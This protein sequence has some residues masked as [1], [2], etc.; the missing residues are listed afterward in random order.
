MIELSRPVR[1]STAA[2]TIDR[3]L[4]G[5]HVTDVVF[6]V[7][8]QV[9]RCKRRGASMRGL[10]LRLLHPASH[11]RLISSNWSV[12]SAGSRR[13]WRRISSTA[14][15]VSRLAW[16]EKLSAPRPSP[17][18]DHPPRRPGRPGHRLRR[19]PACAEPIQLVAQLL[20]AEFLC[21]A[22]HQRRQEAGRGFDSLSGSPRCRSAA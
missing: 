10:G 2:Q 12:G 4:D 6:G 19:R 15:N 11:S 1:R 16:M 14:G 17:A 9:D 3:F 8:V 18:P 22:Q 20:V 5:R 7:R 21:A 13:T